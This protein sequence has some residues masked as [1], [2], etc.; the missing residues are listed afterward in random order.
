MGSNVSETKVVWAGGALAMIVEVVVL[1]FWWWWLGSAGGDGAVVDTPKGEGVGCCSV[2]LIFLDTGC[3]AFSRHRLLV[4]GGCISGNCYYARYGRN[5]SLVFYTGRL[6]SQITGQNLKNLDFELGIYINH[7][8]HRYTRYSGSHFVV[9]L[10]LRRFM[11]LHSNCLLEN[12]NGMP[13]I[14]TNLFRR[15]DE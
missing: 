6:E 3:A 5:F 7:F 14:L 2:V 8:V 9:I 12:F 10:D 13:T 4:W 1:I 15:R 11:H